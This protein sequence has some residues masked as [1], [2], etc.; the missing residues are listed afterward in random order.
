MLSPYFQIANKAA[1]TERAGNYKH[2]AMLWSEARDSSSKVL[3]QQYCEH[4]IE[5][6]EK[7]HMLRNDNQGA[8][9]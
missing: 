1:T 4:R 5:A 7:L 2:A 6:C 9:K 3:N 8:L